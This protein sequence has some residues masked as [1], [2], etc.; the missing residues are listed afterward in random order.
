MAQPDASEVDRLME[1]ARAG[2]AQ[3][4]QRLF[5]LAREFVSHHVHR[6]VVHKPDAEDLIQ[7]VL[8]LAWRKLDDL[9]AGRFLGWLRLVT[10]HKIG[11]H[12]RRTN[13][14][15]RLFVPSTEEVFSVPD[16]TGRRPDVAY[17]ARE[18]FYKLAPRL[19]ADERQLL[20]LLLFEASEPAVAQPLGISSG[21]LRQR[22]LRLRKKL[23][24]LPRK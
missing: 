8:L 6:R 19:S 24:W 3:A 7:E 20:R 4:Q 17:E 22:I 16:E 11:D 9:P 15:G 1:A 12:L 5:E 21:A 13:R 2:E 14:A 10:R 18:L 23:Q